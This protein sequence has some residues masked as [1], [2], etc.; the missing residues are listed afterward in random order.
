[1]RRFESRALSI[2]RLLTTTLVGARLVGLTW[3][4]RLRV[5]IAR[6]EHRDD[7]IARQNERASEMVRESF[8]N[9]KGVVA[10][11]GQ[12]ASYLTSDVPEPLAQ[13]LSQLQQTATS[14]EFEVTRSI[15]ESELRRPLESMFREF[16]EQPF[17]AASIGQVHRAVTRD[18]HEVAVK[19]Q[20]VGVAEILRAD[21]SNVDSVARLLGFAFP[22]MDTSAMAAEI[23]ERILEELDYL[24]EAE[25][26][27]T[28]ATYYES[29]PRIIVPHVH[30][31]LTTSQVLVSDYVHG[32]SFD[33]AILWDQ[34]LKD[35]LGETIF[36]F[37]FRSLYRMH[38]FN[39]DP[40]PGNYRFLPDGRIAFLDYG[41]S[42]SFDVSEIELFE[43]LVKSM[44]LDRNP[45]RFTEVAAS[46]GLLVDAETVSPE[47]VADYFRIYYDIVRE[48]GPQRLTEEFAAEVLRHSFSTSHPLRNHVNVPRSFVVIQRINLGMY[49][50][51]AKLGATVDWRGVA[52]E[53][54]PFTNASPNTSIGE[55]EARWLAN[56]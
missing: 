34:P 55:E 46:A 41:F 15:L 3:W 53:I 49:A 38:R 5:S 2:R 54:W 44:V 56:Q 30:H 28:F 10:K 20:Y 1:M 43:S 27:D 29:H 37:V 32:A 25:V 14:M 21:L 50:I 24:H 31:R 23:S 9:M 6:N 16:S 17:A 7:L 35:M 36:R 13:A 51:L 18:G 4:Y 22:K 26:Q 33:E 40:H 52:E 48:R 8:S 19:V 11:I 45:A 12:M 39:G 47:D 42:K